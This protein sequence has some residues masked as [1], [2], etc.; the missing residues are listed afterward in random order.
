MTFTSISRISTR[1]FVTII[2]ASLTFTLTGCTKDAVMEKGKEISQIAATKAQEETSAIV[3]SYKAEQEEYQRIQTEE[4]EKHETVS[5]RD[6]EEQVCATKYPV[7]LVHG[8]FFRDMVFLNYWGRI[9]EDLQRKGA[10]IYYG[11]QQSAASVDQCGEEL[12]RKIEEICETTGCG[13]V[14]IIAH[15]K[16]GLDARSAISVHGAAQYTASLTTINTPHRG[17]LFADYLLDSAP[18]TL[19]DTV[20]AAYNTTLSGLGEQNPDF[21]AAVSDL[22]TKSCSEFNKSCLDDPGVFYQSY[23]SVAPEASGNQFPLNLTHSLVQYYDG[24]NDGL[25]AVDSMEWGENFTLIQPEGD[26]GITH[27]DV[28]DLN[29][30]NIPGYDVREVYTNILRDLKERG[31]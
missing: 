14:N 7:L 5:E 30:E 13:K 29:R 22:T 20:S 15:S 25:V 3:A 4:E 18:K 16:G 11:D 26:R 2:V 31:F 24:M 10:K 6:I 28:I 21:M 17:C 1:A 19:K 23:G 8:V 9:P 27:G 12:A